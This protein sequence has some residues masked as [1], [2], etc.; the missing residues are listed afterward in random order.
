MPRRG[1]DL[2]KLIALIE[3]STHGAD[4]VSIRSPAML[5]DSDTG[6]PREHDVVIEFDHKHFQVRVGIECRDR[7]AKVGAPAIEGFWAK[8]QRTGINQGVVVSSSGFSDGALKKAQG[9]NIRC[10]SL[11]DAEGFD[12]CECG[13]VWFIQPEILEGRMDCVAAEPI[14]SPYKVFTAEG[15][16]FTAEH[17]GRVAATE[18]QKV[19]PE[20][21]V[22]GPHRQLITFGRQ[23]GY[24]VGADGKRQD[25]LG[26]K[27]W[28]IYRVNQ[29]FLP[30]QYHRYVDDISGDEI[31]TSAFTQFDIGDVSA[32]LMLHQRG[33]E[34]VSVMLSH[35]RRDDR[36]IDKSG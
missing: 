31:G 17:A 26:L 20:G 14:E 12:W 28:L 13:G 11:R 35:E 5:P 33:D 9:Y 2:E 36:A 10:L 30:F 23:Q 15:V 3:R 34:G 4:Q 25:I 24:V 16:E 8:C 32:R 21:T 18:L 1:R 29:S 6:K 7:R 27:L 19:I 22:G